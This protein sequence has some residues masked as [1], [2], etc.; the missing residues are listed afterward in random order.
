MFKEASDVASEGFGLTPKQRQL[1][2]RVLWVLAVSLHISYVCGLLALAG[3]G[4]APFARAEDVDKLKRVNA[5]SARIQ[6]IQELRV[7][8]R[9]YCLVSDDRTRDS[10]MRYMLRLQSELQEI[11]GQVEP[12]NDDCSAIA[13]AQ[14][15]ATQPSGQP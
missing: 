6:I 13:S 4:T 10:I 14:P 1:V 12:V 9:S 5:I 11:T 8:K 7:Q 3:I 2:I 15:P